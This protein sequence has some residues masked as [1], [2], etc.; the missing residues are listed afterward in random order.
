MHFYVVMFVELQSLSNMNKI[1]FTFCF[2]EE[3]KAMMKLVD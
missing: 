2:I 1:K 3:I